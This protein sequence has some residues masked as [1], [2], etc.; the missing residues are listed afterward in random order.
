ML[1]T[2]VGP[3]VTAALAL[4]LAF[5]PPASSADA[6]ADSNTS[7]NTKPEEKSLEQIVV[8]AQKRAQEAQDVPIS[9]YA[10]SNQALESQGI[11]SLQDLS[12]TVAGVQ[13]QQVNPGQMIMSIQGLSDF[14]ESNASTS[15]NGYY[16]DE[17]PI[18]WLQGFMP[19]VGLWDIERVEVLRGPQGTLFGEGSEGGTIRVITKKPDSTSFFGNYQVG[20][21]ETEGGGG[22]GTKGMGSVNLPL[23]Q[24]VLA[25]SVA[26]SYTTLPGW[27]DIPNLNETDSN[28]W[29]SINSRVAVR[30]TPTSE[31]TVDL[32]YLMNQ[33]NFQNFAATQPGVFDP[34]QVAPPGLGAPVRADSPQHDRLDIA[35]LTI[36]YDFGFA[37][38]VSASSWQ[39]HRNDSITD[40]SSTGP[41]L[42]GPVDGAGSISTSYY[43]Y[44]TST[45]TQEVRLV[46]NGKQT[47]DWTVGVYG[48]K[49][50]REFVQAYD[51]DL[52]AVPTNQPYLEDTR[53]TKKAWAVFGDAD[54]HVTNKFSIQAGV[55]YY[56]EKNG[57]SDL[58]VDSTPL[59]GITAGT[60]QLANSTA[61]KTSPKIGA[62]YNLTDNVLLFATAASGFRGG[63]ANAIDLKVYPYVPA[64]F[65]ADS[66]WAYEA[67]VKTTPL[68]GYYLNLYGFD[69]R[70]SELQLPFLTNNDEA[71][72]TTNVGHAT[73]YGAELEAGGEV[74]TGLVLGFN[75][76]YIDAYIQNDIE[77]ATGVLLDRAGAKLPFTSPFRYAITAQY[78]RDL[79]STLQGVINVRYRQSSGQWSDTGNTPE[80][81]V[82]QTE[83]LYASIGLT[84]L[85]EHKWGTIQ[86][87]GDN[88][89]NRD[90]ALAKYPE[91]GAVGYPYISYFRP[92]NIGI[93]YK[94]TF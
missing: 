70:W 6:P 87:Y 36:N 40:L 11:T 27:I 3:C 1:A 13:I 18:N 24:N 12:S 54:L 80:F 39:R 47:V 32:M 2:R 23:V 69:N 79:S 16:L 20:V 62:S 46:S 74:S 88:L 37:S 57:L 51:F 49:D 30:Y 60:L 86:I 67:G 85:G 76:S 9:L 31:L 73:S 91:L 43:N 19:E 7:N 56:S 90:D 81:Y 5:A 58:Y 14:S 72:Y 64:G 15:V 26:G 75:F 66:L 68:P 59:F 28:W 34:E 89:L 92:R 29:K 71:T 52:P 84:G 78:T 50:D 38:L 42:F 77:N 45:L 48:K 93:Q 53:Y 17:V 55:R 94:Q 4:S 35:A 10:I 22:E 33:D 25:M 61:S 82:D 41:S 44:N 8:T 63:G 83:Q 65:G 21:S